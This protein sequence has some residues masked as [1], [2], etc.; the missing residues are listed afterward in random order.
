MQLWRQAPDSAGGDAVVSSY[1]KAVVNEFFTKASR[2]PVKQYLFVWVRK[3][4]MT[5]EDYAF[6]AKRGSL[7][8]GLPSGS[9][10][11]EQPSSQPADLLD[12]HFSIEADIE[13]SHHSLQA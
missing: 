1:C 8:N 10:A 6:L 5:C 3:S 12:E 4:A 7:H 11:Q 13:A 2:Q 9:S